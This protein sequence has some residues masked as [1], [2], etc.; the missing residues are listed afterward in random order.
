[1]N[2]EKPFRV[3]YGSILFLQSPDLQLMAPSWILVAQG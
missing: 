3:D 1:M 2:G